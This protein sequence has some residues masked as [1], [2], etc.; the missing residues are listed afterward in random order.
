MR[1]EQE[2]DLG[3]QD[4]QRALERLEKKKKGRMDKE[5]N[6][7]QTPERRKQQHFNI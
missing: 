5:E 7:D 4:F 3:N 6:P 1:L 2:R